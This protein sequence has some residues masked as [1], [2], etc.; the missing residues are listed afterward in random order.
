MHEII[1]TMREHGMSIDR[2]HVMLLAD[3]MTF[4]V[5][6]PRL[7]LSADATPAEVSWSLSEYLTF[8]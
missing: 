6:H 7:S 8:P 2:R 4:K 1:Y 5:S 3:I